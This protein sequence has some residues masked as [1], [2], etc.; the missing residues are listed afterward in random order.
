MKSCFTPQA[1]VFWAKILHQLSLFLIF[2]LSVNLLTARTYYVTYSGDSG[3]G[4]LRHAL[5]LAANSPGEDIIEFSIGSG[6]QYLELS[7]PLFVP[8]GVFIDGMS[9]PGYTGLP[10]IHFI[11]SGYIRIEKAEQV[12]IESLDLSETS[13]DYAIWLKDVYNCSVLHSNLSG[14]KYGVF[15]QAKS[16][17]CHFVGNRIYGCD[18]GIYVEGPHQDMLVADN[19]FASFLTEGIYSTDRLLVELDGNNFHAQNGIGSR[20]IG[21][22]LEHKVKESPVSSSRVRMLRFDA[23]T[24]ALLKG[25]N[26]KSCG[27][28]FSGPA[29]KVADYLLVHSSGRVVVTGKIEANS[30]E[31]LKLALEPGEYNLFVRCG[32]GVKMLEVIAD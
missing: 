24:F 21:L 28:I 11:G 2:T 19:D 1:K 10:L 27:L 18:Y 16:A 4:S 30:N 23:Y 3:T 8:S 20:V 12:V 25:E 15:S 7:Q 32:G 14:H 6:V 9:Q 17:A 5:N 26:E 13:S 29:Q 22:P 31:L